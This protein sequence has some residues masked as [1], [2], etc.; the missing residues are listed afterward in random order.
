[1]LTKLPQTKITSSKSFIIASV[2][3]TRA[4]TDGLQDF[5]IQGFNWQFCFYSFCISCD[6]HISELHFVLYFILSVFSKF[7]LVYIK[8]Q[9]VFGNV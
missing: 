2:R 7:V 5:I 4:S 3:F 8:I 1:M 6:K 9:T